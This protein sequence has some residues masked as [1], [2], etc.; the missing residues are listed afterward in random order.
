MNEA[1]FSLK[2]RWFTVSVGAVIV[3][4]ILAA[5]FA[6]VWLPR[7]HARD[8]SASLWDEICRAAGVPAPYR[9]AGL[10]EEHAVFPST[11]IVT[12]DML[13]KPDQAAIGRGAT[14]AQQCSMCHGARGTASSGTNAP[15]LAGQSPSFLYKQLRDF[16][17][18][19]RSNDIMTALAGNL[20]DQD[21]RDLAAYYSV[22]TR[23]T[24]MQH[25]GIQEEV[26]RLASNG[27]PMRN[28]GACAT[29]H[30]V[31][32]ARVATPVLDGLPEAYLHDQLM[33]FRAGRRAN[34]INEQMRNAARQLTQ[35]EV[36][37]LARYYAN[38]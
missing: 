24:L 28:I 27:S 17:S 4:A 29:C 22:Q 2:N 37:V 19:H 16:K 7:A 9:S 6:F 5:A 38:R 8:A 25:A 34:D 23:D 11:V 13:G 30:D 32:A 20:S 18:G 10:P 33:A 31:R 15:H 26:P 21:M 35:Q 12:N 1:L 36:D 14:L 3:I